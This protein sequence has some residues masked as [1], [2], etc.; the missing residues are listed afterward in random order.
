MLALAAF[1]AAAGY[2]PAFFWSE[3]FDAGLG[4]RAEHLGEVSGKDLERTVD[5]VAR[6]QA[7]PLLQHAHAKE[8][9]SV[10]EWHVRSR[11][12]LAQVAALQ[13]DSKRN[14]AVQQLG[15]LV[16]HAQQVQREGQQQVQQVQHY[17]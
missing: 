15:E 9:D 8:A 11:D 2:A 5:A 17:C 1:G 12:V 10:E 14:A 16:K 4:H 3:K 6:G 7:D 13:D